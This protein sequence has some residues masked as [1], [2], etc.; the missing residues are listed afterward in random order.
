MSDKNFQI[1]L[2]NYIIENPKTLVQ[3][4]PTGGS[5]VRFD[6]EGHSIEALRETWSIV[7]DWRMA[8]EENS[9]AE[10]NENFITRCKL[11]EHALRNRVREMSNPGAVRL[12][13]SCLDDYEALGLE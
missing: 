7:R 11:A 9:E 3:E 13:V 5:I 4:G 12:I 8:K 2:A 10:D 6:G 1:E